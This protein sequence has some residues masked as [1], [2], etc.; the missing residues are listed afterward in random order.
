[1]PVWKCGENWL[2]AT[3][4]GCWMITGDEENIARK[5]GHAGLIMSVVAHGGIMPDAYAGSARWPGWESVDD[6]K[7]HKD[8]GVSITR[9]GGSGA[10]AAERRVAPDGVAYSLRQFFDYFGGTK[11]WEAAPPAGATACV[12]GW[13]TDPVNG[14]VLPN[15]GLGDRVAGGA[16]GTA[17][18]RVCVRESGAAAASPAP[19]TLLALCFDAVLKKYTRFADAF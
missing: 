5:G 15:A 4:T 2:F 10:A 18:P 1:M 7:F 19:G 11:E 13:R 17:P 8:A 9:E 6:G 16:G 14:E 12:G 3:T